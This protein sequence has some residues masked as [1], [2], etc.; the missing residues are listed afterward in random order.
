[1]KKIWIVMGDTGFEYEPD[2]SI[3]GVYHDESTAEVNKYEL[4]VE[5]G[6]DAKFWVDEWEVE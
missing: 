3:W 2:I 1:M 6:E 5:Y 4:E